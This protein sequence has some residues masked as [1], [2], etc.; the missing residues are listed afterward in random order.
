MQCSSV[1]MRTFTA[2]ASA[3]SVG[4]NAC[5]S[6]TS[7]INMTLQLLHWLYL[8][9]QQ[10]R[11]TI[12][13]ILGEALLSISATD[14][15]RSYKRKFGTDKG[16]YIQ[17]ESDM[18]SMVEVRSAFGK[19]AG[20]SKAHVSHLLQLLICIV[21]GL[22]VPLQCTDHAILVDLLLPL[23]E[24]NE[25]VEWRDQVPVI[26][27]YHEALVRCTIKLIE[28]DSEGRR[29]GDSIS[30]DFHA[31]VRPLQRILRLSPSQSLL[32]F[33]IRNLLLKWP[34]GFQSNTPKEV[35]LLHELEALLGLIGALEDTSMRYD[36]INSILGP[37]LVSS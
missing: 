15:L 9:C 1:A 14:F 5:T 4:G 17:G 11:A 8:Q 25:M 12:R 35:L 16:K 24:P 19:D 7:I 31:T 34:S 37:L 3:N 32:S 22:Q 33:T 21:S 36:E 18:V 10:S 2:D 20:N 30:Q 29:K 13:A 26:Q 23:H 28:K 6:N 27:S